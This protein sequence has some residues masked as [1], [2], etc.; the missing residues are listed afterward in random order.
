MWIAVSYEFAAV[1]HQQAVYAGEQGVDHVFNPDDRNAT[2]AYVFDECDERA[3]FMLG[4]S[5][6]DFVEQ[7]H[8][9]LGRQRARELKP[10]A[11]EQSQTPA[12]L[13]AFSA[14]PQRASRS[15]QR[16]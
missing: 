2:G 16:S 9:R 15:P 8:A 1:Q 3:T 7:Q 12:R 10:L 6:C 4:Q 13:L 11:I 5:A 14:S